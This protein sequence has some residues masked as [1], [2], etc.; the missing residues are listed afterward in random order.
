MEL[1]TKFQWSEKVGNAFPKAFFSAPDDVKFDLSRYPD[2]AYQEDWIRYYLECKAE[3]NGKS[4]ADV[5]DRDVED[6]YVKASKFALVS[7]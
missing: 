1:N 2:K 6:F 5:T 3:L 4:P 7:F